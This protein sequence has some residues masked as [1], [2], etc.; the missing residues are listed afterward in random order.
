MAGIKETKELLIGI[1]EVVVFL[2]T[3][4][5]DGLDLEDFGAIWRKLVDDKDFR[6]KLEAAYG[7][8]S[9]VS[10]EFSDLN[11]A[12]SM[13]ILKIQADYVTKIMEALKKK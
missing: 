13:E 1:N 10:E 2:V 7:D 12:E 8:F 11:L 6:S 3:I 5:K 4:F 9:K